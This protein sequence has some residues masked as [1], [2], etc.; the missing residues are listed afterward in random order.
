MSSMTWVEGPVEVLT[1]DNAPTLVELPVET[2][3]WGSALTWIEGPV[4]V[5]V[6]GE[7]VALPFPAKASGLYVARP[8]G[9][10][11]LEGSLE[12]PVE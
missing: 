1:V 9:W 7:G 12:V 11:E 4:E 10:Y 6:V 8:D 3:V 2:L 5:L